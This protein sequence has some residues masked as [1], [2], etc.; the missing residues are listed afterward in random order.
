MGE[1]NERP[2]Y[3]GR[4]DRRPGRRNGPGRSD[5]VGLVDG[6]RIQSRCHRTFNGPRRPVRE[7]ETLED[8]GR[9]CAPSDLPPPEPRISGAQHGCD[10]RPDVLANREPDARRG[11]ERPPA[12]TPPPARG[13]WNRKGGREARA[14]YAGR[15]WH[16]RPDL[17]RQE[18]GRAAQ[19]GSIWPLLAAVSRRAGAK[20]WLSVNRSDSGEGVSLGGSERSPTPR[21]CE[22]LQDIDSA[23]QMRGCFARHMRGDQAQSPAACPPYEGRSARHLA[24]CDLFR[25]PVAPGVLSNNQSDQTVMATGAAQ[26]HGGTA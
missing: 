26:P 6:A 20:G 4:F 1:C 24:G 8:G 13:Q 23:R 14:R 5:G 11:R 18:A 10:P 25:R 12:R 9:I 19:C 21:R 3:A 22:A 15:V 16:H 2:Q 17:G 7:T